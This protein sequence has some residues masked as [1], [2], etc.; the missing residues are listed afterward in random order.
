MSGDDFDYEMLQREQLQYAQSVAGDKPEAGSDDYRSGI[1][2]AYDEFFDNIV[3]YW[4]AGGGGIRGWAY[5][6]TIG[7]WNGVKENLTSKLLELGIVK[8]KDEI[9]EGGKQEYEIDFRTGIQQVWT[10]AAEAYNEMIKDI[11]EWK[12]GLGKK[13]FSVKG[14][15][16]AVSIGPYE[17]TPFGSIYPALAIEMGTW[18]TLP[19]KTTADGDSTTTTTSNTTWTGKHPGAPGG[20]ASSGTVGNQGTGSTSVTGGN[21]G[22]DAT[23][24]DKSSIGLPTLAEKRQAEYQELYNKLGKNDLIWSPSSKKNVKCVGE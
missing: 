17:W 16:Q 9:A 2:T 7:W 22:D 5:D 4:E 11:S 18:G 8:P 10:W 13:T 12:L 19:G 21:K 6:N 14:T 1:Q 3:G 23:S 20:D 24:D 15:G